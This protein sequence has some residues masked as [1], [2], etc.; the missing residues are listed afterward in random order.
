MVAEYLGYSNVSYLTVIGFCHKGFVN[1][2]QS[3]KELAALKTSCIEAV[4]DEPQCWTK[5]HHAVR[6]K[7]HVC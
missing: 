1:P 7:Q 5:E 6:I 4:N 2:E 3:S